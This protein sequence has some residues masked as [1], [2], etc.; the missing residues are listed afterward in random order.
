MSPRLGAFAALLAVGLAWG[1]TTPLVKIAVEGGF[2][3][4]GVLLWQLVLSV[5]LIGGWLG[6]RQALGRSTGPLVPLG[7]AEWRLYAAVAALGIVG[8]HWVSYT[9]VA[10]LPAGIVSIIVSMVPLFALPLAL[11]LGMERFRPQ[12]LL[13]LALGAVAVT[14]LVVPQA[15]LP[16]A[17]AAGFVLFAMLTPLCYALEGAY[18]AGRASRRA[19]PLQ[20]LLGG[21]ALGLVVVAPLALL[22]GHAVSPLARWGA[23][24][25]AV[26]LSGM[27]T[28]LAYAGYVMLLRATGPVFAAQVSYLVTASGVVWAMVLLGE[29]YSGWVWAALALLFAGLFLVQ[30]RPVLPPAAAPDPAPAREA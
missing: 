26:A 9:A 3:P 20:T 10:H 2:R 22:S 21:S 19:G 30:P 29:R 28:P 27:L 4:L 8:P 18:V 5:A 25:A 23:A 12:R 11:V 24:E 7:P 13:G 16:G 6:L 14:L 15:S 1:I 17:A